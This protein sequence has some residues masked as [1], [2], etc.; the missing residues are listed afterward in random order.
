MSAGNL[1]GTAVLELRVDDAPLASGIDGAKQRVEGLRGSFASAG[2]TMQETGRSMTMISAGAL[3]MGA[4]AL[5]VGIDYESAFA[6]V[7]KT[8]DA[9]EAE[10]GVLSDGIRQMA[11]EVPASAASI[12]SVAEAAGQLGVQTPNILD[13]TRT[14]IDLGVSTNM[15]AEEAATSLARLANITQMPQTE[16]Q[17]LGSTVV[18][19]GNNFATT[20]GEIVEMGLRIAGAG[21]QVGMTE[22][23]ILGF[24]A[25][26]SSVGIRA[27]AGGSAISRVMIQMAGDVAAGGKNLETFASVAGMST[28]QFR[29]AFEEDAA[30]AIIAFVEGLGGISAAGGD[31]FGVLEELGMS[32]VRVRD[33]LL[34]AAGAGDLFREAIELGSVAWQENTALTTEAAQRYQTT[35]S[36]I[37][38]LKNHLSEIAIAL[39]ATF[40]PLLN[41]AIQGLQ[42]FA[43][44]I[45]GSVVPAVN[46]LPAPL[47]TFAVTLGAVTAVAGPLLVVTGMLVA[48]VGAIA[49]PVLI[50]VAAF[51]ALIA[52]LVAIEAHTGALSAAWDGLT[53]VFENA[54]GGA[55]K[56]LGWLDKIPDTVKRVIESIALGG[57]AIGQLVSGDVFGAVKSAQQALDLWRG[58]SAEWAGGVEGDAAR[59]GETMQGAAR[60]T[61]DAYDEIAEASARTFDE[62][63]AQREADRESFEQWIA[64][65]Q[66]SVEDGVE[67]TVVWNMSDR[68]IQATKSNFTAA[69]ERVLREASAEIGQAVTLQDLEAGFLHV[70]DAEAGARTVNLQQYVDMLGQ[71]ATGTDIAGDAAAS[72]SADYAALGEGLHYTQGEVDALVGRVDGL[73]GGIAGLGAEAVGAFDMIGLA[74]ETGALTA[75]QAIDGF[76]LNGQV[77]FRQFREG[78]EAELAKLNAALMQALAEGDFATADALRSRIEAITAVMDAGRQRAVEFGNTLSMVGDAY[79]AI[80]EPAAQAS[81]NL[82]EWE[83]RSKL[84]GQAVDIL[85]Q[86][87]AAGVITTEQYNERKERLTWL[88][89]RSQGAIVDEGDAI[90]DSALKTEEYTRRLDELNSQYADKS[91][92][93]YRLALAALT[94]QYDPAAAAGLTMTDSLARLAESMDATIEKIVNLLV[95]LG[96]FD[97]TQAE[98]VLGV[99]SSQAEAGADSAKQKADEFSDAEYMAV[100][101]GDNQRAID[102]AHDA[103]QRGRDFADDEYVARIEGDE[104]GAVAA[105]VNAK[106]EAVAYAGGRYEAALLADN[107]NAMAAIGAVKGGIDSIPK[108]FTIYADLDYTAL[109]AGLVRVA[110]LLPHSPAEWGPLSFTPDWSWLTAGFA[111]DTVPAVEAGIG[112]IGATL[113]I[114]GRGLGLA[115]GAGYAAGITDATPAITDA[116]V[117][118]SESA[119]E[120]VVVGMA[121]SR[122]FQGESFLRELDAFSAFVIDLVS[123]SAQRFEGGMLDAARGYMEAAKQGYDLFEQGLSLIAAL[124]ASN[125]SMQ[126]ARRAAG[127]LVALTEEIVVALGDSVAW[128]DHSRPEG[129]VTRAAEYAEAAGAGLDLVEQGAG[130]LAAL[131]GVTAD[132]DRAKAAASAIKFLTEHVVTSIGDSARY[133]D[134]P[135]GRGEGFVGQAEAY[136]EAAQAGLDLMEQGAALMATL[137]GLRSDL[138]RAKDGASNVKFLTEHIILSIGDSADYIAAHRGGGFI[139]RARVYAEAAAAGMALMTEAGAMLASLDGVARGNFAQA[140]EAASSVK[141]LTEHIV[142]SLGDSAALF[143]TAGLDHLGVYLEAA[144][145][146]LALMQDVVPAVEALLDFA[147]LSTRGID[148]NAQADRMVELTEY[149][150]SQ[151]QR[152]ASHFSSAG[153]GAVSEYAGAASDA[154]ETMGAA[155]DALEAM[156]LFSTIHTTGRDLEAIAA[157]MVALVE[158]ITRQLEAVAVHWNSEGLAAVG[159]FAEGANAGLEVMATAGE[160]LATILM[161][162]DLDPSTRDNLRQ[163]AWE[164]TGVAE[165]ILDMLRQIARNY[166]VDALESLAVFA[167]VA[168]DLLGLVKGAADAFKAMVDHSRVTQAHADAFLSSWH[169][170]IQLVQDVASL[171][172]TQGVQE[173]LRFLSAVQEIAALLS[174]AQAT[175]EAVGPVEVPKVPNSSGT[176]TGGVTAPA[177]GD[178][179]AEA[180]ASGAPGVPKAMDGS[181]GGKWNPDPVGVEDTITRKAKGLMVGGVVT[182]EMVARIGEE[183]LRE[184]VIPLE[185]AGADIVATALV[186]RMRRSPEW[187]A[188]RGMD[189]S[190]LTATA[191]LPQGGDDIDVI[192]NGPVTIN[193][194][195]RAD[196]QRSAED[197]GWAI[198]AAKRRRGVPV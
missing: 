17:R 108:R 144:T 59:T 147:G 133:L 159:A 4:A 115:V 164:M 58:T 86:Q 85:D 57:K 80:L 181:T 138:D 21:H 7:R 56:I 44:F 94:A 6:G 192:F 149:V 61:G 87:L 43:G 158:L 122:R 168:G 14:M 31:V 113:D 165:Y 121:E 1:L 34:R 105:A 129:F 151:M 48:A 110:G 190:G 67:A 30:G 54:V 119:S 125:A 91:S 52:V 191:F 155:G 140:H 176:S 198:R 11:L 156:L 97:Q 179:K 27:E 134:G 74:V 32:E 93:E 81:A 25:A 163:L 182:G 111:R 28:D 73:V 148:L 60:Q 46:A 112:L 166:S 177:A 160:A 139:E 88:T 98:A 92:G 180:P 35:A 64:E 83:N 12:A 185:T 24:S 184:A 41:Q 173:A 20:E 195:D 40:L 171:A 82:A 188:M 15:T 42:S 55:R 65:R 109:S 19:L 5:K 154:M 70:W 49:A 103:W 96:I 75:G 127:E 77:S 145:G 18:A 189:V 126:N 114:D 187:A 104:S 101:D 116:A 107:S 47:K 38:I 23:Q 51:G 3:A 137:S 123:E 89:E 63:K 95:Q 118:A 120:G 128:L 174:A 157:N 45:S 146:A 39:G 193:A 71:L 175:I 169:V 76:V 186:E 131:D 194:R 136:A 141:F 90:V 178:P 8:V 162:G 143:S 152:S 150:V 66:R 161:Y 84:A 170:V 62:L 153:L 167:E 13:F 117:G 16:F 36:Q 124:D 130:L 9:T 53:W 100:L 26:L 172:S 72:A 37:Q 78:A 69:L 33:A 22:P 132:L 29:T 68:S 142:Q 2:Q 10:F 79:A 183:G 196:A 102:A 50:G 197:I 135:S 99:D 106:G